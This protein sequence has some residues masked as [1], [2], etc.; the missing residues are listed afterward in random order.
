[1]NARLGFTLSLLL[2]ILAMIGWGMAFRRMLPAG[3]FAMA[4]LAG[5]GGYFAAEFKARLRG[6]KR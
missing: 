4:I 1:M 3:M 2:I 6:G 5:L